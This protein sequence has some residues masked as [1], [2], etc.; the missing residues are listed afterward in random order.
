MTSIRHL[1]MMKLSR[2]GLAIFFIV[3]ATTAA[4]ED[5]VEVSLGKASDQVDVFRLAWHK[6]WSNR[7][8]VTAAGEISGFHTISLNHWQG[9]D[10]S[11]DAIAYSPVFVYRF[12]RQIYPYVKFGIGGAWLSDTSIATRNLGSHLQFEDQLGLGWKWGRSDLSLVYM[13]Y[14]NGGF[15]H[16]NRGVDMLVLSY[17]RRI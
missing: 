7:W 15:A 11:L 5:A 4:A 16:P 17:A 14:S 10:G 12:R 13:H 1:K 2:F 3:I 8:L 9:R 6:A